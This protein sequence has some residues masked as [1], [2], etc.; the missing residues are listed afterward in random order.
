MM[1]IDKAI[2]WY[3]S[4]SV[5]LCSLASIYFASELL[6]TDIHFTIAFLIITALIL[7]EQAN[8]YR[9]DLNAQTQAAQEG[10]FSPSSKI[11]PEHQYLVPEKN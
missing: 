4:T 3:K 9:K 6:S 5:V 7:S 2:P 1:Q 8:L 10:T 11:K